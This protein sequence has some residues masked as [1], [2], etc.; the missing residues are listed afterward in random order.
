MDKRGRARGSVV[1]LE[2]EK[3]A[4]V[5]LHLGPTVTQ[6]NYPAMRTALEAVTGVD[7]VDL[8]VD[9]QVPTGLPADTQVR[10]AIEAGMTVEN[11][12]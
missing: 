1:M 10:M 8:L 9:G 3:F 5:L 7:E 12:P 2:G 11:V 6:A 4:C